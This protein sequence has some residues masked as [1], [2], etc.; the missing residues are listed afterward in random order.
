[1]SVEIVSRAAARSMGLKRYFSGKPCPK[2]HVAE[3]YVAKAN[4]V[5][6]DAARSGT[7]KKRERDRLYSAEHAE[8]KRLNAKEWREANPEREKANKQAWALANPDKKRAGRQR[9]YFKDPARQRVLAKRWEEANPELHRES[10][11]ARDRTR[12]ARRKG[13]SGSHT[14]AE[15]LSLLEAQKHR[16]AYCG[17]DLRKTKPHLDHIVALSRGGSNDKTNLQWLCAP[18]NMAKG[19]TDPLQFAQERLGRLM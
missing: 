18:C 3:R 9:W 10:R 2:G 14:A 16:C 17:A 13:A 4:C 1:M 12:R 7:E 5:A 6:C 15:T 8:Q 19:A 11:A